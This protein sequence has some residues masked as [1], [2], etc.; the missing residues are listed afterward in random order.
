MSPEMSSSRPAWQ[1][2]GDAE[3]EALAAL[4]ALGDPEAHQ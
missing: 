4:E 3:A 1:D 2:E